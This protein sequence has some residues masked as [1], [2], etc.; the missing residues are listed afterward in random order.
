MAGETPVRVDEEAHKLLKEQSDSSGRT[1]RDLASEA[2]KTHTGRD[3]RD[4]VSE[5]VN[6]LRE[7]SD[8]LEMQVDGLKELAT[9]PAKLSDLSDRLEQVEE[10]LA[11]EE[12][13]FQEHNAKLEQMVTA[14]ENAFR[15]VIQ[16]LNGDS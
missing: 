2:I 6:R 8:Q 10:D 1:L 11:T 9:V 4:E 3:L 5:E 7:L 14:L 13:A 12:R 15:R 16:V